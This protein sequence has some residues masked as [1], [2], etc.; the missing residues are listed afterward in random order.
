MG[1]TSTKNNSA[2]TNSSSIQKNISNPEPVKEVPAKAKSSSEPKQ[3]EKAVKKE[4]VF[5]PISKMSIV[6]GKKF[7]IF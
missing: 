3:K 7:V 4:P 6:D 5:N 1:C 2:K